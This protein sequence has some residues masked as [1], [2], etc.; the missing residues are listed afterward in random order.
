MSLMF[1]RENEGHVKWPSTYTIFAHRIVEVLSS[2]ISKEY[3]K[4]LSWKKGINR[5]PL[6]MIPYFYKQV[7]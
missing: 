1:T 3:C 4:T 2:N 6:A 7:H 5:Q